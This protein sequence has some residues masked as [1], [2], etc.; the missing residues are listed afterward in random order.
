MPQITNH[1]IASSQHILYP[2]IWLLYVLIINSCTTSNHFSPQIHFLFNP[3]I[4]PSQLLYSHKIPQQPLRLRGNTA[5]RIVIMTIYR[6]ITLLVLCLTFLLLAIP[7]NAQTLQFTTASAKFNTDGNGALINI[8]IDATISTPAPSDGAEMAFYL[9][10]LSWSQT[11]EWNLRPISFTADDNKPITISNTPPLPYT[12]PTMT[13]AAGDTTGSA[14]FTLTAP[15]DTPTY[16]FLVIS[17]EP[18]D[19]PLA[20]YDPPLAVQ[21]WKYQTSAVPFMAIPPSLE[22]LHRTTHAGLF[23]ISPPLPEGINNYLHFFGGSPAFAADISTVQNAP[24]GAALHLSSTKNMHQYHQDLSRCTVIYFFNNT[25]KPLH[26]VEIPT[27]VNFSAE[28]GFKFELPHDQ[29]QNAISWS[30]TCF[31]GIREGIVHAATESLFI[32]YVYDLTTSGTTTPRTVVQTDHLQEK[33]N[34][35]VSDDADIR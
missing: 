24:N 27:P 13:I 10:L 3:L 12:I 16:V 30:R 7:T 1:Q 18:L 11:Y 14:G 22:L 6:Y 2:P 23:P 21:I 26:V 8:G 19:G 15:I 31:L 35:S 4:P 34:F 9:Y 25:N 28:A 33:M 20:D 32:R 17:T 29:H 5:T